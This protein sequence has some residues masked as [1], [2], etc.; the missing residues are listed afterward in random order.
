MATTLA[1]TELGQVEVEIRHRIGGTDLW[2]E[3]EA[4]I[5]EAEGGIGFGGGGEARFPLLPATTIVSQCLLDDANGGGAIGG[6][7]GDSDF[8]EKSEVSFFLAWDDLG[9]EEGGARG[10]GFLG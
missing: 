3:G 6:E 5:G 7:L 10:D 8:L 9:D 2:F 1:P 4:E